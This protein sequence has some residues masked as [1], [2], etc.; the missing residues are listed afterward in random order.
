M[1]QQPHPSHKLFRKNA[2][3]CWLGDWLKWII[4]LDWCQVLYIRQNEDGAI[5]RQVKRLTNLYKV[6]RSIQRKGHK[7]HQISDG[8]A[9]ECWIAC[10]MTT[11]GWGSAIQGHAG[12]SSKSQL[13]KTTPDMIL[14]ILRRAKIRST[15]ETGMQDAEN[16]WWISVEIT[17]IESNQILD[18]KIVSD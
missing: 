15:S 2:G 3:I 13:S 7:R 9:V 11:D 1:H 6:K 5:Y 12:K 18:T 8:W 10:K 14:M 4:G 16:K 17:F